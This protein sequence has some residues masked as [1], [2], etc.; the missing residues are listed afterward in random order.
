MV[1]PFAQQQARSYRNLDSARDNAA[2][3]K[4]YSS[5]RARGWAQR[6]RMLWSFGLRNVLFFQHEFLDLECLRHHP[7]LAHQENQK[8]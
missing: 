3:K 6:F 4:G 7:S 5:S 2:K 1:P 8:A